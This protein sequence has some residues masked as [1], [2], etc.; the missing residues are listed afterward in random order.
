M[1]LK[2]IGR[3]WK[4]GLA[5]FNKTGKI[6]LYI[7]FMF[8]GLS[9]CSNSL[10]EETQSIS[11]RDVIVSDQSYK[12]TDMIAEIYNEIYNNVLKTDTA[13]S[14]ES[15]QRIVKLLGKNGYA[16]VD[17][18][19]QL[20][21]VGADQVLL[22]CNQVDSKEK[23]SL[24]IIVVSHSNSFIKYEFETEAGKVVITHKYFLFQ[25]GKFENRNTSRY[26]A[27]TWQY[28]NEG[29]LL[30]SGSWYSEELYALTLSDAE[31]HVALRVQAL[32]EKCRELN[33]QYIYP[34]GYSM[35]NMF[36]MDWKE[37]DFGELDFYDLY[38]IFYEIINGQ[39]VPLIANDNYGI[40]E[41][42]RIPQES[43]ENT[44]MTFFKIDSDTLR[45]K[46]IYFSEDGTY[47]YKPRGFYE[48]EYPEIPYPE[49][50][51]Y[52]ENDDGTITLTVNA[53][54]PHGDSSKLFSHEVVVRPL[55]DDLF[56]YVSNQVIFPANEDDLWWHSDR[57]TN[58]E[59]EEIYGGE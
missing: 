19:N 57:L 10:S 49:V 13:G 7:A 1:S 35:N 20:D 29:Y 4:N 33:R 48:I 12:D 14:F 18:E 5:K 9:G 41:V 25:N 58:E 42:Y 2:R 59:W 23:A 27:A 15:V 54:Y 53:V 31:E 32:D 50:V 47:E 6:Y 36:L 56:Q 46:T 38:D 45:S 44:I 16:A 40:G 11:D 39:R 17:S 28:T 34:I 52:I 8:L 30:F 51:N 3:F 22:F 26:S 37:T 24:S 43:F 55:K 21:M